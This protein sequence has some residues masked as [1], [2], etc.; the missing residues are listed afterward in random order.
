M[1]KGCNSSRGRRRGMGRGRSR[2]K[3]QA[4][5]PIRPLH[6]KIKERRGKLRSE[7]AGYLSSVFSLE[8]CHNCPQ[9]LHV[10]VL[11]TIFATDNFDWAM[12]LIIATR[13]AWENIPNSKCERLPLLPHAFLLLMHSCFN[14]VWASY[15]KNIIRPRFSTSCFFL[16]SYPWFQTQC[17][18]PTS[19]LYL[20]KNISILPSWGMFIVMQQASTIHDC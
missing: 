1:T 10:F 8:F 20:W 15:C 3:G 5:Q 13:L 12:I 4:E 2:I 9:V 11:F 14:T 16:C 19:Q 18:V 17:T 6:L 7:C